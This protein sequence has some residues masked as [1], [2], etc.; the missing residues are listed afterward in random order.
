MC[1]PVIF[2]IGSSSK[3]YSIG[4]GKIHA[5]KLPHIDAEGKTTS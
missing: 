5:D 3:E 2:T 4:I 1:I